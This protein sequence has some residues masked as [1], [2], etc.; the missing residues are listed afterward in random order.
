MGKQRRRVEPKTVAVLLLAFFASGSIL[1][2]FVRYGLGYGTPAYLLDL[3]VYRHGALSWLHGAP[4]L[5]PYQFDAVAA[6]MPF[7][8][9]PIAA[10]LF[11]PTTWLDWPIAVALWTAFSLVALLLGLVSVASA[12]GVSRKNAWLMGLV[13]S[14]VCVNLEPVA[15]HLR[16]GQIGIFLMVLVIVDLTHTDRRW[17]RGVLLGLAIAIKLNPA[18]FGLYFLL[19][20]DWRAV[21]MTALSFLVL[22]GLGWVLAPA[23]S[24]A[25]W[26]NL[27]ELEEHVPVFAGAVPPISLAGVVEKL[28]FGGASTL[29]WL[30][31]SL[32][33]V[34]LTGRAM[35][36]AISRRDHMAALALNGL[37]VPLL[38]PVAWDHHWVWVCALLG[39]LV[40]RAPSGSVVMA[41]LAV[42][43]ALMFRETAVWGDVIPGS[44]AAY[45]GWAGLVV[46]LFNWSGTYPAPR[47]EP[48]DHADARPLPVSMDEAGRSS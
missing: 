47:P 18:V 6:P 27:R 43:T 25:Y 35:A 39:V 44:W 32:I 30:V 19:R 20:R 22:S 40:A 24:L 23:D 9:P 29:A 34:L 4:I 38:S 31:L 41:A 14:A 36:L 5:G 46:L 12:V 48:D 26:R 2:R 7:I 42:G 10:V 11:V 17:P 3:D 37:L 33:V 15:A 8:Y 21:G 45:I 13:L 1:N 28:P 16:N